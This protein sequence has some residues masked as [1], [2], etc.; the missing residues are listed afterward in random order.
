[1]PLVDQHLVARVVELKIKAG[2]YEAL[3]LH[4]S[5][6]KAKVSGWIFNVTAGPP[7]QILVASTNIIEHIAIDV[8][9]VVGI[10]DAT[11]VMVSPSPENTTPGPNRLTI[12]YVLYYSDTS[13]AALTEPSEGP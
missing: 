10:K 8:R 13:A 7:G 9:E 3:V 6:A 5:K 12:A 4:S 11:L 2:V 1:M